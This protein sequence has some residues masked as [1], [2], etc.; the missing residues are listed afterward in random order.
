[1]FDRIIF[2]VMQF[3]GRKLHGNYQGE[4]NSEVKQRPTGWRV[5]HRAKG[6]SIKMYDK[7]SV[8][9]IETTMN[10]AREFK[11]PYTAADGARCWKPINKG[12]ANFWRCYQVGQQANQ[13][14]LQA[15]AALPLQGEGV[16]ALDALC[17]PQTKQ[18]KR[19]ARFNPLEAETCRGFAAVLAGEQLIHGFC[20][21][22]LQAQLYPQPSADA[23]EAK[24]RCARLSC[25]IA[26]L[27][28]HGL[29]AKV[30]DARLY[31]VTEH[32]RR[33][34]SAAL[35]YS[36]SDFPNAYCSI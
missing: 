21:R 31:R 15:L 22:N 11:A 18:G 1:M 2:K 9:R 36:L 34:M 3:L 35:Q 28:G 23:R 24:R 29:I 26:K 32:G 13:R 10:N 19:Y 7:L 17:R 27:R 25:W 14:Y 20:N 12:G 33:A 16:Q 6:N 5:K 8:V 30:K 4:V